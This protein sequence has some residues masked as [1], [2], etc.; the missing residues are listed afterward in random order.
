MHRDFEYNDIPTRRALQRPPA[1]TQ[2]HACSICLGYQSIVIL[3]STSMTEVSTPFE[4][5]RQG[6]H[7]RAHSRSSPKDIPTF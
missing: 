3:W 6:F 5:I 4:D 1:T 7:A 2:K